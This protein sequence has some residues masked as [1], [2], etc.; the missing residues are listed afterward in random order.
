LAVFD[1][2][3]DVPLDTYEGDDGD[4]SLI[5]TTPIDHDPPP[6]RTLTS[7]AAP[8]DPHIAVPYFYA[9]RGSHGPAV[10]ALVRALSEAGHGAWKGQLFSRTL[11]IFAEKNLNAFKNRFGLPQ[12]GVYDRATHQHLARFY[13]AYAIKHLLNVTVPK[14]D[15]NLERRNAFIAELMYL[16]NR[17]AWE[18][19]TQRR[20]FDT[21]KP[22]SGLDCSASGE[23]AAKW[24]KLKSL[25]GYGAY[26]YGNTDSQ[27]SR[28]KSVSGVR[29]S[30]QAAQPGDPIYY[31][32]G[33][34]PSHVAYYLGDGRVWSFG[35]YPIKVLQHDYRHDRIA[36]CDLLAGQ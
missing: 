11:G 31:G 21:R 16:Y 30:I 12:N 8:P 29:G 7:A 15:K 2:L 28:Y 13:D 19:Y 26:G 6:T 5:P 24:A 35:S 32:R 10:L 33:G 14:V 23:W 17:R 9:K 25:S 36:V 20:A 22:P 27:L 3:H 18:Q 4:D 1:S 34:D